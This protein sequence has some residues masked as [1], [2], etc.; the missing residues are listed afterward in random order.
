VEFLR[1]ICG[2]CGGNFNLGFGRNRIRDQNLP[3]SRVQRFA[4]HAPGSI[5]HQTMQKISMAEIAVF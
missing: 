1:I 4:R 3:S 2:L 5:A